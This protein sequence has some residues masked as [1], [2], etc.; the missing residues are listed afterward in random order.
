MADNRRFWS[1]D[2][3]HIGGEVVTRRVGTGRSS[4][5]RTLQLYERSLEREP[6]APQDLRGRLEGSVYAVRCTICG[7]TR[8]WIMGEDALRDLLDRRLHRLKTA[9]SVL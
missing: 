7:C 5:M 4:G 2:C 9:P 3:G 1:F 6:D 8:D